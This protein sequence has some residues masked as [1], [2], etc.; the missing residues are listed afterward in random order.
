MSIGRNIQK[1]REIKGIKQASLAKSLDV[2][3][4][5][6]SQI[7]QSEE[8]DE[9]LLNSI[10]KALNVTTDAIINYKEDYAINNFN[11]FASNGQS[12]NYQIVMT[13]K[14]IEVYEKLISEKETRIKM[15][16]SQLSNK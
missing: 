4:Q 6:L 2:S 8:V 16:E 15:L 3:Q 9:I 7:E 13:D 1:I 12:I 10:S 5:R 11:S 14:L